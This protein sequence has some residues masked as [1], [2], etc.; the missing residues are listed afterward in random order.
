MRSKRFK[1]VEACVALTFLILA[2]GCRTTDGVVLL[3]P[4]GAR[5]SVSEEEIEQLSGENTAYL[6]QVG[7][8]V[9]MSFRVVEYHGEDKPWDYRIEVGDSMEVRLVAEMGARATYKLDVGDLVGISFLKNWPL[10]AT[11][12]VR[13]DGMLTMAEVGDL[14]AAGL[15][16]DELRDALTEAYR[17]TGII[18][19]DPQITV[20]VDF[21]NP[22]RLESMSRDVVVRPDGAIR[23]PGIKNDVR[24]A[25]M[26]IDEASAALR[27]EAARVLNNAPE[28]SLVVFPLVNTA[29]ASMNTSTT[30]RPDG[31]I[32]VLR[33]GELQAA[34]FSVAELEATLDEACADAV[35]FNKV[36]SSVDVVT[37][38]GSRVYVGGEVGVAGVYPLAGAPTALQAIMMARGPSPNARMNNVIVMRRNPNGKPFIFK[39]NLHKALTKGYTENDIML[40]PFDVIYVPRKMIVRANLFVEQYIEELIPFG[41]NMGVNGT[42]YM[43]TQ[44]VKTDNTSKNFNSGVSLVPSASSLPI[45]SLLSP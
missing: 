32:S 14:K 40:R 15:T 34:G 20:N 23:I 10:N 33:I 27:K 5:R 43:N 29:L 13:P 3:D 7:D 19:G 17:E 4:Q 24:I 31:R 39:M 37:V 8:Q 26:T 28:V 36:K 41:N 44:K 6:M 45:S 22:D 21:S 25:G 38:T 1:G 18:E 12:T 30:V 9:Q 2:V 16:A 35:M 42:Y 11:K